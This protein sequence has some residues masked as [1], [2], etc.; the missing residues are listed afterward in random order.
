M[1]DR[2]FPNVMPDFT[3]E[4][5]EQ[6]NETTGDSLLGLL[7]MSYPSLSQRFK[8]AALDLKETVAPLS[9][10]FFFFCIIGF[11]LDADQLFVEL[12]CFVSRL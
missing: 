2:F 4:T 9:F 3:E 1:S 7:S 8:R 5:T 10:F 12:F 11:F 6:K